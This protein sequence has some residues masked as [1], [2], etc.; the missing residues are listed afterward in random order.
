[1]LIRNLHFYSKLII[2]HNKINNLNIDINII[3]EC[4]FR[5]LF[6][7][8]LYNE[9]PN[10]IVIQLLTHQLLQFIKITFETNQQKTLLHLHF[11]LENILN[12]NRQ[13]LLN[14]I[15]LLDC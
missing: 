7:I 8:Q 6:F 11:V 9:L 1:Y 12:W 2:F 10:S 5:A 13:Q 14:I 3:N 4:L 15:N